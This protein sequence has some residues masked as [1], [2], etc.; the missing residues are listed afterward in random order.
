MNM[1]LEQTHWKWLFMSVPSRTNC[2]HWS[3]LIMKVILYQVVKPTQTCDSVMWV[4]L[5]FW[6]Q[7]ALCFFSKEDLVHWPRQCIMHTYIHKLHF[8]YTN[9]FHQSLSHTHTHTER[10]TMLIHGIWHSWHWAY[11]FIRLNPSICI[12]GLYDSPFGYSVCVCVSLS[13]SV[14]GRFC[15]V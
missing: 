12:A 5:K 9:K 14:L 4:V 7:I 8:T 6:K 10:H 11:P 2:L 3:K 15:S 1:S 13:V